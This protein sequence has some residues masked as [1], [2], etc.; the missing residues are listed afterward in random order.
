MMHKTEDLIAG[1]IKIPTGFSEG[2]GKL[3]TL[4]RPHSNWVITYDLLKP[5]RTSG[6]CVQV[7][8]SHAV[9]RPHALLDSAKPQPHVVAAFLVVGS[10]PLAY[11][12]FGTSFFLWQKKCLLFL[13]KQV[14]ISP[15]WDVWT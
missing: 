14:A 15:S 1:V 4:S 3:I 8:L 7:T 10:I 5:P 11:R 13:H 2:V 6:H 9:H 12:E